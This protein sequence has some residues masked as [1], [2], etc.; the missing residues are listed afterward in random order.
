MIGYFTDSFEVYPFVNEDLVL[1][2]ML[3]YAVVRAVELLVHKR[4]SEEELVAE[5]REE[6][7]LGVFNSEE[8]THFGNDKQ[9]GTYASEVEEEL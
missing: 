8:R 6:I 9:R 5:Q 7:E 3:I 2:G 4:K 1:F